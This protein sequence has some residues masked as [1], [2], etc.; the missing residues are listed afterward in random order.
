[1]LLILKCLAPGQAFLVQSA[2]ICFAHGA[3]ERCL[4]WGNY[5]TCLECERAFRQI[6]SGWNMNAQTNS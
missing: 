6:T 1:M 4:F 2:P 5:K 3:L